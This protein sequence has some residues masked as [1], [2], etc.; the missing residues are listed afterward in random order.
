MNLKK[1]I[2]RACELAAVA[3]VAVC[4]WLCEAVEF[5][6]ERQPAPPGPESWLF[7]KEF[8]ERPAQK[9]VPV[10]V[11]GKLK[12]PWLKDRVSRCFFTPIKRPPHFRDELM[13]DV[14][15]YPDAYLERLTAEGVN[16]LWLSV[17]FSDIVRTR[18]NP[19]PPDADRR[20]AKL[21]KTVEKCAR[22]GIK[23]WM[24]GIEPYAMEP[25]DPMLKAHPEFG[26]ASFDWTDRICFC[27][28]EPK[29]LEYLEEAMN[30]IF[31]R[32]QGL[33]GFINISNGEALTTC[34]S[35]IPCNPVPW[36]PKACLR[37]AGK[38]P[39]RL[40]ELTLGAM[41]KGMMKANPEAKILSWFYHP[42]ST[43]V[44]RDWVYACAKHQP[45]G[46]RI[47][48]NNASGGIRSQL[49]AERCGGDYW[50]AY[51]GPA[52]P[53]RRMAEAARSSR[54]SIGAKLQ[55]A[56][57]HEMATIPSV[58]APGVL[59]RSFRAMKELGVD[60]AMM[61]WFFG[62]IPGTMSRAA[63]LLAYDDFADGEEVFL[64]RLAK[65]E[66]GEDSAEIA[67]LWEIFTEAYTLYPFSNTMQYWGPF[68]T[69]VAWPLRPLVECRPMAAT[70]IPAAA[71]GLGAT[72]DIGGD[73]VMEAL[74]DFTIEE[75][76]E[77]SWQMSAKAG[78]ARETVARLKS[79]YAGDR[80]RRRELG[81]MQAFIH[82]LDAAADVFRFYLLRSAAVW[83]SRHA[84]ES[85]T[86]EFREM[87][88]IARRQLARAAEMEKLCRD[89]SR[90]GFHSE[91][92]AH[93][94]HPAVFA[95]QRREQARLE[96]DFAEVEKALAEGHGY[97]LSEVERANSEARLDGEWVAGAKGIRW[98]GKMRTD[99]VLEIDVE[100]PVAVPSATVAF[101]DEAAT[102]Y[103]T[104]VFLDSKKCEA[105][106]F[107]SRTVRYER[108]PEGYKEVVKANGTGGWSAHLAFPSS[109][110]KNDPKHRPAR[111][112]IMED[113]FPQQSL[114][115]V[116]WPDKGEKCR[117]RLNLPW[118]K[119]ELYG[120]L[121]YERD[122]A[123]SLFVRW[124]DAVEARQIDGQGDEA[125]D[126]G[127]LCS[128]YAGD[129]GALAAASLRV[130]GRSFEIEQGNFGN[131]L[132]AGGSVIRSYRPTEQ[133]DLTVLCSPSTFPTDSVAK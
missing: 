101:T 127:V 12:E 29:V 110:W 118:V 44:R 102:M 58:P 30:D 56:T 28:S 20:L 79:K 36:T 47:I 133:K 14:D 27:P 6:G 95:W 2:K 19:P 106:L 18:F 17:K 112:A 41:A 51:P 114:A 37:C 104:R 60:S 65:M 45:E 5:S 53:F 97:P 1:T 87:R 22:H 125:L 83:K 123:E 92:Q 67:R 100:F 70:W 116:L 121:V 115:P 31:T 88:A 40:H 50:T 129:S 80:E 81:M 26:G 130:E 96:R 32:V 94:Y 64:E 122:A 7:V 35:A 126:G 131:L 15:Y 63:G 57:S 91:A 4:A 128:A 89:D 77:L 59:Y 68:A 52:E 49:G 90:L 34:L 86:V 3:V 72:D 33:G 21:R 39:W 11:V 73:A 111:F 16:G 61:C 120:R 54:L 55:V 71:T 43:P 105:M 78:E 82:H 62:N 10:S 103:S 85:A 84:G 124:L 69:G 109:L 99:G 13:D 117:N 48:Y 25:D 23:V 93:L 42:E 119:A 46:V 108:D 132:F 76:A 75:A 66:W 74:S 24:F 9:P 113:T 38:E 8:A 98:R 107:K